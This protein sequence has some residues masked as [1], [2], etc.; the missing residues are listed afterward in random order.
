MFVFFTNLCFLYLYRRARDSIHTE[1]VN[2]AIKNQCPNPLIGRI[3]PPVSAS[4][5]RLPRKVRTTLTQLRSIHCSALQSYQLKIAKTITDICPECRGAPQTVLHLFSCPAHPTQ[6]QP[7]DLWF[8][9]IK[10]AKHLVTVP[11]FRH[12]PP[13]FLPPPRPPPEPPP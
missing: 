1:A 6:L 9:P 11:T 8:N 3:A 4:E 10:A 7:I 2:K 13:L 12:L 5:R